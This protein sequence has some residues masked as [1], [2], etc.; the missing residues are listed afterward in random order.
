MLKLR[1]RQ[2][3]LLVLAVLWLF[4]SLTFLLYIFY[5]IVLIQNAT[6]DLTK[7][8]DFKIFYGGTF[9]FFD[10]GSLYRITANLPFER[11]PDR[12]GNSPLGALLFLPTALFPF[13]LAASLWLILS[14]AL[15]FWGASYIWRVYQPPKQGH[16]RALLLL[17]LCLSYPVMASLQFGTWS[18][19]I[20][21]LDFATWHYARQGKDKQAGLFLGLAMAIRWQPF[22]LFLYFLV[23]RRWRLLAYTLLTLVLGCAITLPLFGLNN[24]LEFAQQALKL[25]TNQSPTD[26]LDGSLRAFLARLLEGNLSTICWVVGIVL[27][28]G[29][30][31]WRSRTLS[32]DYGYSLLLVVGLL[33][34]PASWIHYHLVLLLPMLLLARQQYWPSL[35]TT[36]YW[37]GLPLIILLDWYHNPLL[38]GSLLTGY[39]FAFYIVL[40]RQ[41]KPAAN[42]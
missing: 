37:L 12:N 35:Y 38:F 15:F 13:T 33:L 26:P 42:L 19:I 21:F 18:M 41:S 9:D 6:R 31:L 11:P 14:L 17:L 20:A 22:A 24:Y 30:A 34:A 29:A 23:N 5:H 27:L 1:S 40:Y 32:F 39:L 3:K 2:I 25:S 36:L 4:S 28:L 10:N 8:Y 7:L 16:W